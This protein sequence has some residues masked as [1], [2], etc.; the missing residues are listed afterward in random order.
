MDFSPRHIHL[1][2]KM[3]NVTNLLTCGDANTPV[4]CKTNAAGNAWSAPCWTETP[5]ATLTLKFIVTKWQMTE[6]L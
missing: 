2:T 5:P 3:R 1:D 4:D 6:V